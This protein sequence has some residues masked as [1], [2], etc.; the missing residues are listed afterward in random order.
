MEAASAELARSRI[1]NDLVRWAPEILKIVPKA[2]RRGLIPL[3]PK[4]GQ[5]RLERVLQEQRSEGKAQ[6]AI[7]LK[8]RQM[9]MSTWVQGKLVTAS[10]QLRHVNSL[11]VVHEDDAVRK[12]YRIGERMYLNLPD[13]IRPERR[14]FK[15]G[16]YMHFGDRGD[17]FSIWPD[18]LYELNTAGAK[19]SGRAGTYHRA[20]L[21]EFAFWPFP[22]DKFVAVMQGMTD[23]PDS[24]VVIES[25]PNGHN[26]YKQLWDEAVDGTNEFAPVFLPWWLEEEYSLEFMNEAERKDFRPGDTEQSPWAEEELDL[27]DPG[28][29]DVLSGEFHPLTLEQLKW[30]RWAIANKTGGRLDKFHQE[31]PTSPEQ[32]FLSSGAKVFE[33]ILVSKVIASAE[34]TDP[35]LGEGGPIRGRFEAGRMELVAGRHGR[36]ERPEEPIFKPARLLLPGETAD[37]RF[38]LPTEDGALRIEEEDNYVIG[39]DVSEGLPESGRG[40]PRVSGAGRD[41]PSDQGSGRRVPL[42][43]RP[44]AVRS[45]CPAHRP[46]VQRRLARD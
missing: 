24:L 2:R 21:S 6:R 5:V 13:E 4:P 8:A 41:R 29:V 9:G 20:H 27:L 12:M 23:D 45:P 15:S 33:P 43:G 46:S 42:A 36:V 19:E 3:D 28:P 32:A 35:R 14:A 1:V 10:T 17:A 22:E 38:W 26:L 34:Q 44:G 7:I 40:R 31:Y 11:T 16:E 37:W 30:R 18:S 39:G 25:T